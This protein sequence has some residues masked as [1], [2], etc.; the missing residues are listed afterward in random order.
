MQVVE[1]LIIARNHWLYKQLDNRASK[2]AGS[3]KNGFSKQ[4]RYL[5]IKPVTISCLITIY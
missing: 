3:V 1:K 2:R 5:A 4:V